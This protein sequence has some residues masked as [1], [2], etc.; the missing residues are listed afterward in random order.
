MKMSMNEV[1]R[2]IKWLL[3][4]YLLILCICLLIKLT[5]SR[6]TIYFTVNG[7]NSPV[8]DFLAPFATDLGNGW[9]AV[10][11]AAILT[12]FS[13]RKAFIVVTAWGVTSITAQIIKNIVKSP[14]PKL[15]FQDQ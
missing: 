2:R 5:Y 4:P 10:I 11:I 3:I 12:L 7:L 14:R 13:Y 9:F 15:Y 6:E 8:A 1:L